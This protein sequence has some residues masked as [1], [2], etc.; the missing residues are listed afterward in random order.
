MDDQPAARD[1][2]RFKWIGILLPVA[3]VWVFEA[4]RLL[5][6]DHL[7]DQD[8]AHLIA[9]LLMAIGVVT[10]AVLMSFAID[11]AQR[12]VV[13]QNRDLT[14]IYGVSQEVRGGVSRDET[15]LGAVTRLVHQTDA[16]AGL[17]RIDRGGVDPVVLRH[18]AR[19]PDGLSWVASLLD[20]AT[21]V[22]LQAPRYGEHRSVDA[23]MLD[24]PLIVAG[25]TIGLL[26]LA[27][28]PAV[29]PDISDAALMD[30]G[31]ELATAAR[32]TS[33]MADLQRR[34]QES[35]ALYQVALQLTGK[36]ELHEVLDTITY[37]ARALLS[38]D[39]AVVCLAREVSPGG[40][41]V[42]RLSERMAI[43]DDGG[44]CL[45]AHQ[46]GREAHDQN[47][48]CP[49]HQRGPDVAWMA[50]PLRAG[51]AQLGEL[52]VARSGR[53][54][55]SDRE[56]VL[57]GA[58]AD[59]AA[60]AVR[61]AHLHDS[62]QQWLVL[63]E[64]DRIARELHD[65]LAQVL[66]VLHLRLRSITAAIVPGASVEQLAPELD[67]LAGIADEAYRDVREAILGLRETVHADAGLVGALREYLAKYS[68]Q[69]GI[70][71]RLVQEAPGTTPLPPRSEVQLLRVVQEA[72]TNVRKHAHATTALV[73]I[74]LEGEDTVLSIEDDGVGF[75]PGQLASSLGGGFG[76]TTMRER[77]EQVGGR[78]DVHTAAGQGTRLIVRLGPEVARVTS[79]ASSARPA[80]R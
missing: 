63:S 62:E 2:R 74:T 69:T 64:R 25:E 45:V 53:G 59:M 3:F 24:V 73:R 37:H 41:T 66:G 55:F 68:R 35:A 31:G 76:M 8:F 67:E 27:F 38:A 7:A 34:E 65:S 61:T 36:T 30:I 46:S 22:P 58:L 28:H 80:H 5:V 43:A 32:L 21:G 23:A 79:P 9:A 54:S 1:L 20:E 26:R 42:A 70:A 56:R 29:R 15:L 44:T 33:V 52:C 60:I 12:H 78:L 39:R 18:P 49:M 13:R 72:L 40:E 11:R 51:D 75:D 17:V 19:L 71:A 6:F 4:V 14:A 57:L 16:L 48:A 10:F 47:E 77:V 50:R